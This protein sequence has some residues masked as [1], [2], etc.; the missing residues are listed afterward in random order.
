MQSGSVS[1]Q[2]LP[3]NILAMCWPRE[4]VVSGLGLCNRSVTKALQENATSVSVNLQRNARFQRMVLGEEINGLAEVLKGFSGITD[5][6]IS[7]QILLGNRRNMGDECPWMLPASMQVA[8]R[9][10]KHLNIEGNRLGCEGAGFIMQVLPEC[11]ESL[12]MGKNM[13]GVKGCRKIGEHM[14][15][16]LKLLSLNVN[17]SIGT[18]GLQEFIHVLPEGLETLE[19]NACSL[20]ENGCV[21]ILA[22]HMPRNLKS[23]DIG[24]N[25]IC[26]G[27]TN[28]LSSSM[29][30]SL[31]SLKIDF[32]AWTT[33]ALYVLS[34]SLTSLTSLDLSCSFSNQVDDMFMV[35]NHLPTTLT[36]LGIRGNGLFSRGLSRVENTMGFAT[37]LQRLKLLE[38]LDIGNNFNLARG[39][40]VEI[41]DYAHVMALMWY[42]PKTLTYLCLRDSMLGPIGPALL[43]EGLSTS[44]TKLDVS[45]CELGTNGLDDLGACFQKLTL[46]TALDIS[47]NWLVGSE[48]GTAL[49]ECIGPLTRL[50]KLDITHNALGPSG[51]RALAPSLPT[52]LTS[53]SLSTCNMEHFWAQ[54]MTSDASPLPPNLDVL[55][56]QSP[57]FSMLDEEEVAGLLVRYPRVSVLSV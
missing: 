49:G 43:V 40:N 38:G 8:M 52:S 55:G 28:L 31:T 34:Y 44:L 1:L 56:I 22:A 12:W 17:G 2:D 53:L 14:P 54:E 29:P 4:M 13:I 6:D 5:L 46:L 57:S 41:D 23:L 10:L 18:L 47:C 45:K 37:S 20:N 27:K 26:S 21:D 7:N 48:G 11:I 19:L 33:V 24:L 3:D 50:E 36:Y 15:R 42:I 25:W 51:W 32:S 30:A 35:W 9:G 16:G 39:W